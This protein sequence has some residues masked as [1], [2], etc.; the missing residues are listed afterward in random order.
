MH[1]LPKRGTY[2]RETVYRIL[3]KGLVCHVGFV[4]GPGSGKLLVCGSHKAFL[5]N[6]NSVLT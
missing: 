5:R 3:D 2:E 4:A 1:R 6:S